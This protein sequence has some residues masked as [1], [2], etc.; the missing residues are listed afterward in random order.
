MYLSDYIYVF[1]FMLSLSHAYAT[2]IIMTIILII[3]GMRPSI[4]EK[5]RERWD[6]EVVEE[7][8]RKG[9]WYTYVLTII[10]FII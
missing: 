4:W 1:V 6:M 2:I 3:T 8:K 9:E 7:K 5:N 10:Y